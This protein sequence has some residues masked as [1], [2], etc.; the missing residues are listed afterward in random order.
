M[1]NVT[2]QLSDHFI[3]EVHTVSLS[4]SNRLSKAELALVLVTATK[5]YN[6]ILLALLSDEEDKE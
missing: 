5:L 6:H 2:I 1:K 4:L 3:N